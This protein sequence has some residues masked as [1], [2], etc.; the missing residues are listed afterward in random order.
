MTSPAPPARPEDR[1]A[2]VLAVILRS[3][4][5]LAGIVV[6]L[7]V[8]FSVERHAQ[9]TVDYRVFRGEPSELR[10]VTG[11]W[12]AARRGQARGVIQLGL[13]LLIA[14]PVA[15][16]IFAAVVFARQRDWLY[17][18]VASFVLAALLFGL[19]GASF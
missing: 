2:R 5:I 13:L 12:G 17:A 9:M 14:T 7:G 1:T 18:A 19:L 10:G 11:V 8:V 15:R 4:V 6:L 3:G 16:V